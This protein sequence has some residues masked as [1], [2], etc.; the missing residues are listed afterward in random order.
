MA[1]NMVYQASDYRYE[2][3][4][5]ISDLTS[6]EI[7]SIVRFNPSI[8]NEIYTRRYINNIYLDNHSCD[9]YNSNVDGDLDRTKYRIR[10]YGELFGQLNSPVLELKIKKGLLGTKEY[11]ILPPFKLDAN[12]CW[13]D[14]KQKLLAAEIPANI[15]VNLFCMTPVLLNRYARNY[16]LSAD[17]K[18]RITIDTDLNYIKIGNQNNGY[19]NHNN[20]HTDTILELKYNPEDDKRAKNISSNFPFRVTKSSKYVQGMELIY[21]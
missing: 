20:I 10:W 11:Y 17:K 12:F 18:F 7:T 15:R 3:K 16:Y 6:Q 14:L 2:R 21:S 9:C 5:Y 1:Y 8:F 19:L 13:S 4:Y